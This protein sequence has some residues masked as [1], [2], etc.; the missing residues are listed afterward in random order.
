MVI[1]IVKNINDYDYPSSQVNLQIKIP[2]GNK[3]NQAN[4]NKAHLEW[5]L[6]KLKYRQL[7]NQISSEYNVILSEVKQNIIL[8]NSL[9]K[10]VNLERKYLHN[11]KRFY[12]R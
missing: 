3:K 1:L 8:R 10:Q 2:L 7:E 9:A 4:Y 12:F 6:Q 11:A 5:R